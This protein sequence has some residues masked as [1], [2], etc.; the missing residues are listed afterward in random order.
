MKSM[1]DCR[2]KAGLT[3]ERLAEAVGL[4]QETISQYEN[5]TRVPNVIVGKKK[6]PVYSMNH[7]TIFFLRKTFHNE[8]LV[9]V[10]FLLF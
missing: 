9:K 6:L 1:K 8:M 5:G 2:E 4:S 10:H 7:W 3:Q